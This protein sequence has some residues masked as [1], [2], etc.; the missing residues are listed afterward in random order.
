MRRGLLSSCGYL[1]LMLA[2][3]Q[4]H[5]AD[6]EPVS[7]G[8]TTF[9]SIEGGYLF[10]DSD[11]NVNYD[12]DDDKLGDLDSKRPGDDGGQFRFEF[13]QVFDSGWDYKLAVG[14]II[15]SND[16]VS[17]EYDDGTIVVPGI[18]LID[19]SGEARSKQNL[20]IGIADAELGYHSDPGGMDLRFFG[21]VRAIYSD[22]DSGF[23]TDN[24]G[25]G[26]KSGEYEDEVW[27]VGPRVG[28]DLT[29]PVSDEHRFAL[30]GSV[31]GSVLFG[32]REEEEEANNIFGL[33]GADL[34]N[35]STESVTV[36]NVDAMAG[37]QL[38]IS[39][40]AALTIGYKGHQFG[41]LVQS[42]TDI[43]KVWRS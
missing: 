36:W 21:G 11:H 40:N 8:P 28:L 2:A 41:D 4:A 27:A 14:A 19:L 24:T 5:A 7:V 37:V 34:E 17:T 6:V 3:S 1:V 18:G 39:N 12:N 29:M 15:L 9:I 38:A 31:S 26:D 16:K 32:E 13:G 25:G 35:S 10:N 30:V 22:N 23:K 33:L 42:R 43:D 20:E